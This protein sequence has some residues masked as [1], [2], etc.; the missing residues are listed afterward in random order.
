MIVVDYLYEYDKNGDFT[1]QIYTEKCVINLRTILNSMRVV[2]PILL[3]FMY[4]GWER[5]S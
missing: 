3:K 1:G 5:K 2:N 4:M